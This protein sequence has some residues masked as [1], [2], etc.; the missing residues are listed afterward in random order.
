LNWAPFVGAGRSLS[1]VARR[2]SQAAFQDASRLLDFVSTQHETNLTEPAMISRLST[3]AAIFGV[4]ASVSLAGAASS[5]HHALL[6]AETSA[7]QSP[8]VRFPTVVVTAKRSA[9]TQH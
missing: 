7:R 8:I 9:L 2:R 5:R 4:L 3:I 6:A 1:V